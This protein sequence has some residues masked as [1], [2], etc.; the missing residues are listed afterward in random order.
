MHLTPQVKAYIDSL[1]LTSL[2]RHWKCSKFGDRWFLG[3]SGDYWYSKMD[4]F[5]NK[6]PQAY[7]KAWRR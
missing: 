3:E 1:S 2:I 5:K 6:D 4:E 7:A